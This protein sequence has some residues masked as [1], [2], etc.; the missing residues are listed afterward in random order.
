M[1]EPIE[2]QDGA[3]ATVTTNLQCTCVCKTSSTDRNGI[4]ANTDQANNSVS[5]YAEINKPPTTG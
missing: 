3:V 4:Q 1:H 5:V 2:E